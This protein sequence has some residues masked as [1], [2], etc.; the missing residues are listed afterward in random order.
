[1]LLCTSQLHRIFLVRWAPPTQG[2]APAQTKTAHRSTNHGM[3]RC[4][5]A[6][7]R[8]NSTYIGN[9]L[10]HRTPV[11]LRQDSGPFS[12]GLDPGS[13]GPIS[14]TGA[15]VY[16]GHGR[17][18]SYHGVVY[19]ALVPLRWRRHLPRSSRPPRS[20]NS[21]PMAWLIARTSPTLFGLFS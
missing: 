5:G 18:S 6:L 7:V 16:R 11:S 10:S 2:Q 1:M 4:N 17:G 21:A 3:D 9:R 14:D 15:D 8:R 12:V 20:R 19:V 13:P